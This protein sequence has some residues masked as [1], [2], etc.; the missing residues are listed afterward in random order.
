M[1]ATSLVN[2]SMKF[3]SFDMTFKVALTSFMTTGQHTHMLNVPCKFM[4]VLGYAGKQICVSVTTT[5]GSGGL[6]G[7]MLIME[8]YL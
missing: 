4:T 3:Y 5:M 2:I 7:G 8:Y 6:R 1:A